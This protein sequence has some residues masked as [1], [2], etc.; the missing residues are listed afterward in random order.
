MSNNKD[1]DDKRVWWMIAMPF[2]FILLVGV[3]SEIGKTTRASIHAQQN[4]E[5][6]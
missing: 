3:I 4:C 5:K 1:D 6:D 2:I